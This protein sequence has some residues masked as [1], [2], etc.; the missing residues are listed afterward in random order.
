[1]DLSSEQLRTRVLLSIQRALLGMVTPSLRGVAVTWGD[2]AINA[3][4]IYDAD[5][6]AQSRELV[7][8]SNRKYWLTSTIASRLVS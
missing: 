3:R 1:M 7:Q 2:S 6:R 8:E 4:F 5:D